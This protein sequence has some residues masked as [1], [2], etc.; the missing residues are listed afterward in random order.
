MKMSLSRPKRPLVR[1]KALRCKC[2]LNIA[3]EIEKQVLGNPSS[4]ASFAENFRP[5]QHN[6]L[7]STKSHVERSIVNQTGAVHDVEPCSVN[8]DSGVGVGMILVT[9]TPAATLGRTVD[10]DRLQLRLRLRLLSPGYVY[11]LVKQCGKYLFL[12]GLDLNIPSVSHHWYD[13]N[14]CV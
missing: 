14:V 13:C 9:P 6:G 4:S 1:S 10:S 3:C 12:F 8:S 2:A 5:K 7:F 11:E